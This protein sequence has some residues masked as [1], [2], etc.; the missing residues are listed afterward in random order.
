MTRR[1]VF[2]QVKAHLLRQNRKAFDSEAGKCRYR[3]DDGT[4]CA[5]GCLIPDPYYSEALENNGVSSPEVREALTLAG[6]P[7][8]D[9]ET[10]NMLSRLQDLHDSMHESFWAK[11][12][13][14]I[15]RGAFSG[16]GV[17]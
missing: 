12:L 7:V 14:E 13:D 1:E 10:L 9:Y 2:E 4:R 17:T 6:V 8:E 3:A 15:E 5:V 11:A 16:G